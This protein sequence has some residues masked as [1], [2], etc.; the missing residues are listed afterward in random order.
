MAWLWGGRRSARESMLLSGSRWWRV[1]TGEDGDELD[2]ALP[3]I[4]WMD[5]R[6]KRERKVGVIWGYFVLTELFTL[7]QG[8]RKQAGKEGDQMDDALPLILWKTRW[9]REKR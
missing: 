4:L 5:T 2:A 1:S 9:E 7:A 6:W 3:L 8:E